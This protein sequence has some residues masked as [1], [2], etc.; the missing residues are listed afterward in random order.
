[1]S[2]PYLSEIRIVSF[3]FP[4]QGWALCNGQILAINQN[5]ALFS[6]LGTNYGGNGVS[7]FALPNLQGAVPLHQGN[8]Y[9]LGETG[10]EAGHTLLI[11]EFPT[12]NHTI[13][14]DAT[15]T[16][17]NTP[18]STSVLGVS[19]GMGPG[20]AFNEFF[21]GSGAPSGAISPASTPAG[22]SQAHE[23]RAPYLTLNFIIALQ[24][25]FPSRS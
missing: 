25:I 19:S 12:H 23:N 4:P 13:K 3:N 10:G 5:Q 8:G 9:V 2:T 6:L 14:A 11:N 22:S 7:T 15:S 17:T 16:T 21:Y 18:T 1:M 24:G 20:G